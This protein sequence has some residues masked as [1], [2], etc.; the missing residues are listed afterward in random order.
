[1]QYVTELFCILTTKIKVDN[2]IAILEPKS[3]SSNN[4]RQKLSR[5][6]LIRFLI[7][8]TLNDHNLVVIGTRENRAL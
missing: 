4:E 7:M 2:I 8:I 1:M 5:K 6:K 3:R